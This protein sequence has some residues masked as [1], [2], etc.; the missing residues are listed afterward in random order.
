MGLK[1]DIQYSK[2]KLRQQS[3]FVRELRV[4]A[5][6]H[7]VHVGHRVL[8]DFQRDA[9]SRVVIHHGICGIL[10]HAEIVFVLSQQRRLL[11]LV[12]DEVLRLRKVDV[13]MVRGHVLLMQKVVVGVEAA[14]GRLA[15][16][17][18]HAMEIHGRTERRKKKTLQGGL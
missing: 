18:G 12:V 17:L 11:L 3:L 7:D 4:A 1:Y 16:L 9:L 6:I 8:L 5:T 10:V 14:L 15:V 2:R 13:V